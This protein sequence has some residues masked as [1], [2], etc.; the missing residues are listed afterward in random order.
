MYDMIA[1][2]ARESTSTMTPDGS[3]DEE[4]HWLDV[5]KDERKL[6]FY[7][8]RSGSVGE[9]DEGERGEAQSER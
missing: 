2:K 6:D 3:F 4:S 1:A 8:R 7:A 5:Q 9:S